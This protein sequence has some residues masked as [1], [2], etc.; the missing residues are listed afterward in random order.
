MWSPM[1]KKCSRTETDLKITLIG[2]SL[3]YN[4]IHDGYIFTSNVNGVMNKQHI[5][6]LAWMVSHDEVLF[7]R[8]C[9][10]NIEPARDLRFLYASGFTLTH[11]TP[12][13]PNI[14]QIQIL[15][16]WQS[17]YSNYVC[18]FL[19]SE[20]MKCFVRWYVTRTPRGLVAAASLS[21]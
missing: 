2:I 19:S 5:I 20:N 15:K 17:M 9:C 6:A 14:S 8:C 13:R 11:Q 1:N 7:C 10:R 21:V 4:S 3:Q 12:V 18:Q 16:T